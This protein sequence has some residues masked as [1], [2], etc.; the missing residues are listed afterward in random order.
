MKRNRWIMIV[1]AAAALLGVLFELRLSPMLTEL[2]IT[3]V[4]NEASDVITA[5]VND[6]IVAG[7]V[8]YDKI[9]VLE[10]NSAGQV[11][12][13]KTNMEQANQLRQQVLAL[14]NQ[15]LLELNVYDLGIPVGNL[16]SA[17]VLAGWGPKI[18]VRVASINNANAELESSF[19]EAGINQTLHQ[20][21]MHISMDVDILIAGG[22]R[23]T[24]IS[25]PVVI[26]ETI[27]VGI[28][29]NAFFQT[30]TKME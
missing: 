19:I 3:R 27:I 7:T 14:V 23:K 18:P 21:I 25:Q 13:L 22:V 16:F 6:Q 28:V 10:K 26:A 8:D 17:A 15:R 11:T 2:A 24:T 30:E 5:A 4:E 29:P 20:I 9:I 12:A 1:L